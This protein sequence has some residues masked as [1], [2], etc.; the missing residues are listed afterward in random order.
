MDSENVKFFNSLLITVA[1]DCLP[2]SEAWLL[3]DSSV[4]VEDVNSSALQAVID[5]FTL[6]FQMYPSFTEKRRRHYM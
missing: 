6:F 3:D 1:L 4:S 5:I 2:D